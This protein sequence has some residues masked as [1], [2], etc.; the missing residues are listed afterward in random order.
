MEGARENE[1]RGLRMASRPLL[2][3]TFLPIGTVSFFS[4]R[5]HSVR[6]LSLS[7]ER[8]SI[9]RDATPCVHRTHVYIVRLPRHGELHGD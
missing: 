9:L 6:L 1:A 8:I 3:L 2:A 5:R 7:G 4:A